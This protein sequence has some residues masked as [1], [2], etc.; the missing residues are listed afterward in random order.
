MAAVT[1]FF[2]PG[3][4]VSVSHATQPLCKTELK[5]GI[6]TA[7]IVQHGILRHQD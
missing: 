1:M 3:T 6:V 7:G 4:F 2:L 5:N